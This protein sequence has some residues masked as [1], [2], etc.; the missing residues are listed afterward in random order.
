M[1]NN[2]C[3][4]ATALGGR[5]TV[6]R[7]AAE[8]FETRAALEMHLGAMM[9]ITA[10]I[11]STF[12]LSYDAACQL[13]PLPPHVPSPARFELPGATGAQDVTKL[14]AICTQQLL[15]TSRACTA[16]WLLL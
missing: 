11:G 7:S 5:L 9:L 4:R 14:R 3:A 16:D 13:F 15:Q 12:A 2:P 10:G 8:P 1:L 6:V